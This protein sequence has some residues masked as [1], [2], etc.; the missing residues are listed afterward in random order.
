MP[1]SKKP[2]TK[3]QPLEILALLAA[4][5]YVHSFNSILH[6]AATLGYSSE[7]PELYSL[8]F[9]LIVTIYYAYKRK[10]LSVISVI[11]LTI[12][13]TVSVIW[14]FGYLLNF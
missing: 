2:S 10:S 11:T 7:H 9:A 3:V 13:A 12:I 1:Q 8:A 6:H 14:Y 4:F 5:F